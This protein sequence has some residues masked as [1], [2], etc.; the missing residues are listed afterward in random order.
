MAQFTA[1]NVILEVAGVSLFYANY[2]FNLQFNVELPSTLS[3]PEKLNKQEFVTH[4]N[5]LN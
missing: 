1:N 3:E 2:R 4:I 5:T